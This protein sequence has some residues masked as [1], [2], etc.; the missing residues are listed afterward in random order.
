MNE[1]RHAV[2]SSDLQREENYSDYL[3]LLQDNDYL[4][5]TYDD[6]SGGVSAVHKYHKFDKQV[7]PYG[8]RRGE[9]ERRAVEV[10]RKNGYRVILESELSRM[11]TKLCDGY[12]NDIP[13]EIKA[14]EGDGTW[15]VC[16]KLHNASKQHAQC[17]VL[18]F[19]DSECYSEFRVKDG[20]RLY[21]SS[22]ESKKEPCPDYI[23]AIAGDKLAFCWDKKATPIEG[24]SIEEGLRGQNGADPFT[25]P[26]SDAKV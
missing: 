12:L 21:L 5:V 16:T 13:M 26:P 17:A 24:W 23:I 10:L 19:P 7:G 22:P 9:Y 25:I 18:F 20:L 1:K 14:V 3:R 11:E 2:R 15:A 8:L 6:A 4:D